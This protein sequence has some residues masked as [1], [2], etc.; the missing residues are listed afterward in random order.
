MKNLNK[1]LYTLR[2]K[3]AFLQTEK[4]LTGRITLSGLL[5]DLDK[6]VLLCLCI[7]PATCSNIHRKFANHHERDNKIKNIRE[8]IIDWECAR[9]TKPTKPLN[10]REVWLASYPDVPGI[11]EEL[12]KLNL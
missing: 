11:E 9:I 4:K 10:A 12:L 6:V 7:N 5:H 3:A 8:A 1:I 2:H